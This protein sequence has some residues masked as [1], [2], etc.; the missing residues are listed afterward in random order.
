MERERIYN[1]LAEL[2]V[3]FDPIRVQVLGNEEVPSLN[4][5]I[6]IIPREEG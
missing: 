4:E 6:A 2:N 5:T 3:D 1:F